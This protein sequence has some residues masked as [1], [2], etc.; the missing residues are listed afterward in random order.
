MTYQQSHAKSWRAQR[1]ALLGLSNAKTWKGE[2]L[3][4]ITA[5]MYLAPHT[6]GGRGDVCSKSTEACRASCLVSSGRGAMPTV[7]AARMARTQ[8]FFDD[9]RAF[10]AQL[11]GEIAAARAYAIGQDMRLAVRLNGT[12][13]IPWE[14]VRM[15]DGRTILEAWADVQFYD[16][17]KR[18]ERL[19]KPIP[20]NYHLTFSVQADTMHEAR[21]ALALGFNVA[22][23]VSQ[24]S[25]L[26]G[27]GLTCLDDHDCRFLDPPGVGYLTPK[28]K[29]RRHT[30][31]TSA[32]LM[33]PSAILAL[34]MGAHHAEA[35]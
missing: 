8:R 27:Y 34:H 24:A 4:Y 16:Y 33:E 17:T 12:S 10:M 21:E 9:R 7:H 26:Q 3:G 29:L 28:G 25:L 19:R 1:G 14:R 18:I 23:V 32:L 5:I 6:M 15:D 2:S 20:A 22:C 31:R 13:D 35:A 30:P 11:H